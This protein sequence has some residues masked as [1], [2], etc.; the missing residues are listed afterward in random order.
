MFAKI[1]YESYENS[2]QNITEQPVQDRKNRAISVEWSQNM[3]D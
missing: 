3:T 1:A 2:K